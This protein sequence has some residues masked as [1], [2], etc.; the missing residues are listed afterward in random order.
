MIRR[1]L[2]L[3]SDRETNSFAKSLQMI[4]DAFA[5]RD[6]MVPFHQIESVRPGEVDRAK[7]MVEEKRYSVVPVSCNGVD[8]EEV[9]CTEHAVKADRRI[10]NVRQTSVSDYIPDS[11]PLA[12]ALFLFESREWYL[13]L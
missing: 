9:F 4:G 13:T 11:T 2:E 12:D 10:T 7:R 1:P 6:V 8:F 3:S 5:V